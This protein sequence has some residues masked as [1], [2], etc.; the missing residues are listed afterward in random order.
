M[1]LTHLSRI[2]HYV[3]ATLTFIQF[4]HV[5]LGAS[6]DFSHLGIQPGFNEKSI[7]VIPGFIVSSHENNPSTTDLKQ[8]TSNLASSAMFE[9]KFQLPVIV[10]N[11]QIIDYPKNADINEIRFTNN[12]KTEPASAYQAA[13]SWVGVDSVTSRVIETTDSDSSYN[14]SCFDVLVYDPPYGKP[15]VEYKKPSSYSS[16][17]YSVAKDQS[18]VFL[19]DMNT[20]RTYLLWLTVDTLENSIPSQGELPEGFSIVKV[21]HTL[22]ASFILPFDEF[23]PAMND[24]RGNTYIRIH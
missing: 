23:V 15:F 1:I 20:N 5:S 7:P 21:Y 14:D 6:V 10:D 13:Y 19:E 24:S 2:L 17:S 18:T 8:A 12:G 3:L 16:I 22:D 9:H 4:A 11:N